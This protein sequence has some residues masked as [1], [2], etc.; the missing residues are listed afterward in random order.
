MISSQQIGTTIAIIISEEK[1]SKNTIQSQ[2]IR[3]GSV[4]NECCDMETISSQYS[5]IKAQRRFLV[6]NK[7]G[8]C[9]SAIRLS[10]PFFFYYTFIFLIL[11]L[12]WLETKIIG[13]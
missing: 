4:A 12:H 11:S 3:R 13:Y 9:H 2:T 7:M 5:K 1:F 10:F 8:R 6:R